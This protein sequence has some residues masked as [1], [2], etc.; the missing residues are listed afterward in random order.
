MLVPFLVKKRCGGNPE[1]IVSDICISCHGIYQGFTD[2][3][4]SLLSLPG[5]RPTKT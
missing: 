2:R 5:N 3:M 4:R 1:G